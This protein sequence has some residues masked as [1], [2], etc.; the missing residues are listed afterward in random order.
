MHFMKALSITF[1]RKFITEKNYHKWRTL[2]FEN[3]PEYVSQKYSS[4]PQKGFTKKVIAGH[5]MR[6]F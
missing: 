5:G 1:E 2:Q 4:Q 3:C 6:L